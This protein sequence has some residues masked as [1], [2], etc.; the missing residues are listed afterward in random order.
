MGRCNYDASTGLP[1][2]LEVWLRTAAGR[3]KTPGGGQGKTVPGAVLLVA[4]ERSVPGGPPRP[5]AAGNSGS[6]LRQAAGSRAV[7]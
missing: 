5:P 7:L 6:G 1:P 2:G 3:A 4:V